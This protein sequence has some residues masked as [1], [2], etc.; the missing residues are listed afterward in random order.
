MAFNFTNMLDWIK[1]SL[2]P[3]LTLN[4][5]KE[6]HHCF[7][8]FASMACDFLWSSHNKAFHE[9]LSFDALHLSRKIIKVSLEHMVAWKNISNPIEEK[10]ITPPPQWFKINF[11]TAIRDTFSA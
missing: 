9:V 10:W 6:D 3:E 5:P 8:I 7:Q 11:H 1:V 4:I 2:S